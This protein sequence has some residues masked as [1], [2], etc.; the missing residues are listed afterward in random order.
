MNNFLIY[1]SSAGTGKT[2]TLVKEYLKLILNEPDSF[3]NVL[4]VTF[5]NKSAAEM[6]QRI[7]SALS[8]LSAGK[9]EK[10]NQTL[11]TEGVKGDIKISAALVLQNILHKYSYF[12]VST[13]D[14]FFH[15]VIR[16]FARELKLQLG[17]NIELDQQAV[18]DKITDKLLDDAG[19]DEVLTGFLEDFIYYS[20][21][22]EKGWKIDLK[23]K[24]LAKEIFSE[25]FILK[26][27]NKSSQTD[28][29]DKL[30]EFIGI[31]FAIKNDFDNRMKD[32]SLKSLEIT[33]SYSLDINHFPHKKGGYINYLLNRINN[34]DYDPKQRAREASLEINKMFNKNS[35]QGV[36]A[37]AEAGLFDLL[38]NAVEL[39]D[40]EF[41]KYNTSVNLIK[42]IYVTGIF[43]DLQE[44]LKK[45]RDDNNVLL[46]SDINNLLLNV[47]SGEG[48]PFVYEK[49]GSFYKNFLIDEFQDTST[50]QWQN[51]FPLIENSLSEGNCSMIV[52][53]VKQS[54]YRWRNG[55]MKLLLDEVKNSLSGFNEQVKEENLYT[56][57]RSKKLII[58]FN[59]SFFKEA[60][61]LCSGNV[62]EKYQEIINKV[63]KDTQQKSAD[64][65]DDGYI[66]IRFFG[67]DKENDLS[68]A[69]YALA[70]MIINIKKQLSVGY[71]QKDILVLV[72]KK[73]E[74]MRAAHAIIDAKLR[75]ISAESL[76][77]TNSPKVRLL[78]NVFRFITDPGNDIAKAEI[79]YNY[80]IYIKQS[81]NDLNLIFTDK[82]N[83]DKLFD[84][85]MPGNFWDK[86]RSTFNLNLSVK[87]I[88][89]LTEDLINIF[90]LGTLPDAY[91]F[92][93]LDVIKKYSDE[94]NNDLYGFMNWWDEHKNENTIIV[95]EEEDAIRVMTIHKAKGLQSPIVYIPFANWELG[96]NH[97]TAFIWVS[98]GKTPFNYFHAY[99]VNA[100]SSLKN[101]YFAEDYIEEE[102]LTIL[103][104]LNL[105]Y[106]AFTRAEDKL[107]IGIPQ[108]DKNTFNAG[109]LILDTLTGSEELSARFDSQNNY[110]EKGAEEYVT[111]NINISAKN[112]PYILNEIISGKFA[113]KIINKPEYKNYE[114]DKLAAVKQQKNRGVI[115]H[116]AL[117]LMK[118]HSEIEIDS[119]V[120]VLIIKG[121]ISSD[122][123]QDWKKEIL[124]IFTNDEV[125]NWFDP[126]YKSFNELDIILP[127]N[128]NYLLLDHN[129]NKKDIYRPDKVIIIEN[130]ILLIDYKTGVRLIN[131]EEQIK[132]YGNILSEMGYQ[133][134]EMYLYYIT[135]NKIINVK[136]N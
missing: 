26:A 19:T 11:I 60:A 83:S 31:L 96:I 85:Y 124:E 43:K 106:V 86:E 120:K 47:I 3:K 63:Y 79:L 41:I 32:I 93:F 108:K 89:P 136:N 95:P 101:T 110:Y 73:D 9:D 87:G 119:A 66:N 70:D 67:R 28:G 123:S 80:L 42:T 75:V 121:L 131:N 94:S 116:K 29:K 36:K 114:P 27:G 16:S 4:A 88:Y 92:R 10:L 90:C 135:E 107:F 22:D 40:K 100:S 132:F 64:N 49:I 69:E 99:L 122:Q 24:E 48:T 134:I 72:R 91:L 58:D 17:Y 25:R 126:K 33:E 81:E 117:S 129:G 98:S 71:R 55:N 77:L 38:K 51:F 103:D 20:I 78:V 44:K 1:R 8:A 46:I 57:Y 82:L 97:K 102:A 84:K 21:D 15:R 53:D 50:I 2:Y 34:G 52:G 109:K 74:A 30:K 45:Y 128:R 54:I 14:S 12:S 130:K 133:N 7:I 111:S 65:S 37:V 113:D 39:Y 105:L 68:T 112:R 5:T 59:N 127:K 18:L 23:I 125:K 76:M 35:A 13:I 104:N 118:D 61:E 6:K 56:N 62:D 115:L